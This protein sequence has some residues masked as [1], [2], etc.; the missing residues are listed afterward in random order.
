MKLM[1]SNEMQSKD[2]SSSTSLLNPSRNPSTP[3][4]HATCMMQASQRPS[5]SH[6][7]PHLHKFIHWHNMKK[8]KE[9]NASEI[10]SLK[11]L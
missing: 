8:Q 11:I 9:I 4:A 7:T 5:K 10:N 2:L 6:Q 3:N 1:K